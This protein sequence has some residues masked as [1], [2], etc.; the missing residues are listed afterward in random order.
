ME[1]IKWVQLMAVTV[2]AVMTSMQSCSAVDI[3]GFA[4]SGACSGSGYT[5]PGIAQQVCTAM[6]V[7]SVLIR[8]LSSCQTG[9]AYRGGGCTT[10]VLSG[11]GPTVWCFTGGS[12]T[13][14]AWFNGCR[15]RRLQAADDHVDDKCSSSAEPNGVHY[16]PDI[17]TGSWIVKTPD[18]AQMLADLMAVDDAE[19]VN[20]LKA[21]GA[22]HVAGSHHVT[23]V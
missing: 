10:A 11:N 15:R 19:K 20:W 3:Q 9:R 18:A 17:S 12:F 22:Y 21:H 23:M 14:A 1:V 7:G 13:G 16:T 5:F 2:M 8:D 6:N 4:D